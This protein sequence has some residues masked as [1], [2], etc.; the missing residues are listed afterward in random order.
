MRAS[1]NDFHPEIEQA[2]ESN[3]GPAIRIRDILGILRREWRFPVFGCLIGLML[4]VAYIVA[5][6]NL[7]KSS[8]RIL[9]D[10]S[11]NRYLQT[12]K[13]VDQP[14]FDQAE[15]ES[16]I[17]ILSSESI[18]VP[19]VRS[20]DLARDSEFVGPPHALG[21]K[22]LKN[23]GDL[24][25]LTKRSIGWDDDAIIESDAVRERIAV[26]S[27]MK[28]LNVYRE[29][30]ANVITVAF[31]SEDPN[32]AA[33][34]A[35]A[36]ADT[37]LAANLEAKSKSTKL[38]S[39]WLQ[40][41]LMELKVQAIEADRA[42]Q[43]Y[44][45]ANNLV[46]SEKGLQGSEQLSA[47]N[48]QLTN[49][50]MA[51]A[52]AK[53]RFDRIQQTISEGVPSAT[54]TDALN[55]SV[56]VSLR[57]Q[58]LDLAARAA[59]IETRVGPGH[60][61]VAK[62]HERMNELLLS[63]RAEEQRLAGSYAS[64]YQIAK[65]RESELAATIAKLVG[66]ATTRSQAQVTMRDIESSSDTF[67]QLY[68]NFL[69]KFQEMNTN[70]THAIA[71][72]DAR[73]VTR[74]APPLYK[75]SKKGAVVLAGSLMLGLFLGAG[76]AIA[77]ELTSDVFRT[78]N[79][80]K[81]ITGIHCVM[82]PTVQAN[83]KL[84]G[85][86][87]GRTK[88]KLIEEIVL[89]E[90]YS[91][92]TE[93]LRSVKALINSARAVHN[94]KVIGVVSSVPKEG[95]TIIAANLAALMIATSGDRTLIIDGDL[96]LRL[97]TASLA[98]DAQEGLIEALA[99]PSRLASLVHKR[100]HSGLDVLPCVLA[101]RVPNAAELLGSPQ[102]EQLLAAARKVYDY[103][104]IEIPPIM[105]VVDVIMIERFIDRFIF[106]VEWGQTKRSLVLE[107]LSEAQIIRERLIG[108]VLNKADP[109][110][111]RNIEAYKGDKFEDYYEG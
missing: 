99:D 49:A 44:K 91:R 88:S 94:A 106:V 68:S 65:A 75:N 31:S 92:F 41:R 32:K 33:N 58:Y 80:V 56:I 46:D 64:E 84:T 78:P 45:I 6:P 66:E 35:N 102:M 1:N 11:M 28:H 72:Q 29:D 34:I 10:R 62:L 71:A 67:R 108:M 57:S 109:I 3:V 25:K 111:L 24:V 2:Y 54:V 83:R 23:I 17:H 97:L 15:L 77:R 43:N 79:V 27:F 36:V 101:S 12:N 18:I 90:P 96:H 53:A 21:P 50:R 61:A 48:T 110:A 89:D 103:I 47:L 86:L 16:Q 98:P 8:A 100:P 55:N 76:A 30:V 42:L 26:D 81:E 85:P 5:Q 95:K 52:D 20:M 37:Y 105:S 104:I 22:I 93:S 87:R 70:Q 40:D 107:A 13:I 60:M 9:V 59:E 51:M 74:A 7:Y 82:L 69:Q 14:T 39:Q 38:A 19:V 73:I 4:A 63:I